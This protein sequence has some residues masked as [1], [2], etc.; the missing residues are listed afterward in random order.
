MMKG[1][2][3]MLTDHIVM[4][5]K[6]VISAAREVGNETFRENDMLVITQISTPSNLHA[7]FK[8]MYF[9]FF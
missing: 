7:S 3:L 6:A 4:P 2:I 9:Y 1:S 5:Y 8:N